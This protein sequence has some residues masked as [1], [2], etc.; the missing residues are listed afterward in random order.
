M[1]KRLG[2]V[3]IYLINLPFLQ[4]SLGF[5][6]GIV[7]GYFGVGPIVIGILGFNLLWFALI[8]ARNLRLLL[9]VIVMVTFSLLGFWRFDSFAGETKMQRVAESY[10]VAVGQM[11][12]VS[13]PE[14]GSYNKKCR[15]KGENFEGLA[16]ASFPKTSKIHYGD[17]IEGEFFLKEPEMVEDFDY[18][19]Y[20]KTQGIFYQV[21]VQG[22]WVVGHK[23]SFFERIALFREDLS[24]RVRKILPEPHASLA[25]G[26]VWGERA[27][28]PED[29]S[30]NLSN[31]GTTH[32]I[33][34]SG[35]NVSVIVLLL[36]KLAGVIHRKYVIWLTAFLLFCFL[37]LVGF[38]NLPAMRAGIMGYTVLFSKTIGRK[39]SIL[40]LLAI[41]V[42]V[43]SIMNPL[44]VFTV[45]FQ[46]S[47]AATVGI[48]GLSKSIER[49]SVVEKYKKFL[50]ELPATLS[51]ILLTTPVSMLNFETFSI[52]AL[53]VNLLVL[54]VVTILTFYSAIVVTVSLI[55]LPTAKIA[56]FPLILI[57]DYIIRVIN[58][59]GG[60]P[61]AS[62]KIVGLT[63]WLVLIIYLTILLC[64]IEI[65]Y[66]KINEKRE[67]AN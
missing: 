23:K 66:R 22:Y 11:H 65:S 51:A 45:S 58:F 55:S 9:P 47:F 24:V 41:A 42:L 50:G 31:T 13:V 29:F 39:T 26:L 59:F 12:V 43:L 46:L 21:K 18:K 34:V 7:L 2:F 32:I 25:A 63:G 17:V 14:K 20:L 36:L 8:S 19:E 57:M 27:S 30:K 37:V 40:S 56:A 35:F 16:I 5:V 3:A 10:G 28:M 53:F 33:A 38:D 64:M 1:R 52:V 62:V 48:V 15:V 6:L 44:S 49:S 54:P 67:I 61:F 4:A 60:L